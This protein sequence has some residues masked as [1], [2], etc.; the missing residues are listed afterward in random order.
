MAVSFFFR[1][2]VSVNNNNN[3]IMIKLKI[4][5]FKQGKTVDLTHTPE[6]GCNV[7]E[8]GKDRFTLKDFKIQDGHDDS[9]PYSATLCI[10]GNPICKCVNDGWGGTTEMTPFDIKTMVIMASVQLNISRYKWSFHGT[11][12]ALKLDFIADTLACSLS[13]SQTK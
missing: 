5:K 9:L 7:I 12:F 2:F 8:C 11:E 6:F 13:A 1:N 10:N 4:F 3:S